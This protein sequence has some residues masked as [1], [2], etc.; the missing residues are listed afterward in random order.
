MSISPQMR[1]APPFGWKSETQDNP[2]ET[3]HGIT[4]NFCQTHGDTRLPNGVGSESTTTVWER[5]KAVSNRT[6]RQGVTRQTLLPGPAS[7]L[8]GTGH[9]PAT[10]QISDVAGYTYD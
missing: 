6:V 7:F 4:N 9:S 10:Q 8:A 2:S 1:I 5:W 3:A